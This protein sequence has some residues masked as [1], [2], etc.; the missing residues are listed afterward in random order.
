MKKNMEHKFTHIDVHTHVNLSAYDED[1]DV[2]EEHTLAEGVAHINVGTQKDTSKKAV[3]LAEKYEGMYASIGVHPVHTSRSFHDPL[4]FGEEGKAFTSRGEI[5][6]TEYYRALAQH[7]K[8]V[9]IGECGL[10]YYRV[11]KDTKQVQEEAFTAQIALANELGKPLML[12]IRPSDGSM[13]A[14]EDALVILKEHAK[15]LGNVHFFAGTYEVAKKFW[16]IGFTT[17]FT[18][19]ITFTTQ[20][21]EVVRKAPLDM[22]HGE[23][24]APY[25]TPKPFRG[26]RNEPLRVREVYKRIAE[27]RGEDPEHVRAQLLANARRLFGVNI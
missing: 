19:V 24:D 8:V 17:S 2:V 25:V 23:T 22:L 7:P 6:D 13:D 26:Q 21:D 1:R 9:A 27:L 18:G 3:E 12:H 15:V 10:D 5:F 20:Y 11:E 14:Y 4:E 16:D